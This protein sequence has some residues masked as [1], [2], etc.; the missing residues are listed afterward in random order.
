MLRNHRESPEAMSTRRSVQVGGDDSDLGADRVGCC[1]G[2]VSVRTGLPPSTAFASARWEIVAVSDL[3]TGS[4]FMRRLMYVV[5][6]VGRCA[7][8][9]WP[10]DS[11]IVGLVIAAYGGRDLRPQYRP[12]AGLICHCAV[13][14]RVL[15]GST[16]RATR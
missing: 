5:N 12:E 8:G 14:R 16:A 10:Y 15:P 2:A 6:T 7:A 13:R 1:Q 9:R 4:V 11:P 3:R